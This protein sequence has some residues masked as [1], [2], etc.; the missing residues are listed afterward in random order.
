MKVGLVWGDRVQVGLAFE[1]AFG[2]FS[3]L[4]PVKVRS[5]SRLIK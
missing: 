1:Q 3:A 5:G 4:M 2:S